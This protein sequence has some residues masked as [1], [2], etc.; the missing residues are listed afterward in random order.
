MGDSDKLADSGPGS[1]TF[2]EHREYLDAWF[3]TVGATRNLVLVGHD[4]GSA[5]G[6]DCARRH[7]DAVRGIAYMEAAVRPGRWADFPPP[8]VELFRALRSPT[9]EQMILENNMFVEAV[10]PAG[11]LNPL[12]PEVLSEYRRPFTEPG[13]S[14]RP[15]LTWPR[16]IPLDGEPADVTAIME[17]YGA[18]LTASPVPKLFINADPGQVLVGPARDFCRTWPNQTE[19]TVPG[20]HFIQEDSGEQVGQAL[21]SWLQH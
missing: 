10:L 7:P 12:E 6:F 18:W 16:Q 17:D 9:G 13:E 4:W 14:R 2:V 20:L 11:V 15:T 19:G 8:A 3:E 21:R 5:L 1:Y